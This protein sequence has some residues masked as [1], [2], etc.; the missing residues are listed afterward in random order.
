MFF[1]LQLLLYGAIF[2]F[3]FWMLL[4]FSLY[5]FFNL[6]LFF[7]FLTVLLIIVSFLFLLYFTVFWYFL[8]KLFN[9]IILFFNFRL[10]LLLICIFIRQIYCIVFRNCVLNRHIL[11]TKNLVWV[12][13]PSQINNFWRHC[14]GIFYFGCKAVNFI[15]WNFNFLLISVANIYLLNW[16]YFNK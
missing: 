13:S 5:L 15:L 7:L 3:G 1:F 8:L 16:I 9:H 12:I 14:L 10:V 4:S 2:F 6:W 11:Y